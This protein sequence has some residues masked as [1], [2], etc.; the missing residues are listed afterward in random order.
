MLLQWFVDEG[1]HDHM[2]DLKHLQIVETTE[3]PDDEWLGLF[4]AMREAER[5]QWGGPRG[6][7]EQTIRSLQESYRYWRSGKSDDEETL[8]S[9]QQDFEEWFTLEDGESWDNL[10]VVFLL[11]DPRSDIIHARELLDVYVRMD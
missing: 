8:A 2:S 6:E 9:I 3:L 5:N 10:R 1:S 7:A 11:S 4:H